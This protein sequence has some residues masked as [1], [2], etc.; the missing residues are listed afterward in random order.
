MFFGRRPATEPAPQAEPS[1]ATDAPE[2]RDELASYVTRI[3]Y[4]E[5]LFFLLPF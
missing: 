5:T 1:G 2:I 4:Q 3:L